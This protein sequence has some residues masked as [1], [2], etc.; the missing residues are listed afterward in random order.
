MYHQVRSKLKRRFFPP[1]ILQ[2]CSVLQDLLQ[3]NDSNPDIRTRGLKDSDGFFFG[4]VKPPNRRTNRNRKNYEN[5][6][7]DQPST[8]VSHQHS[9]IGST[10][11]LSDPYLPHAGPPS[12][13]ENSERKTYFAMSL[14]RASV[15][16][17]D[18]EALRQLRS[19]GDHWIWLLKSCSN[20][21]CQS[22]VLFNIGKL[23]SRGQTSWNKSRR[24]ACNPGEGG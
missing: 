20:E 6:H 7:Y 11:C 2:C 18:F 3:C 13:N 17:K 5:Y 14:R 4:R 16:R 8:V 10:G 9:T 21:L 23:L 15:S 24:A 19:N 12:S 1:L 22:T